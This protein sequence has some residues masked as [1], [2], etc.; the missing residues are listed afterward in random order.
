MHAITF[1][2]AAACSGVKSRVCRPCLWS[3]E[4]VDEFLVAFGRCV[5]EP[6]VAG[7][8]V[9]DPDA[10]LDKDVDDGFDATSF[11]TCASNSTA[12]GVEYIA[13]DLR[14]VRLIRTH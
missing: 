11:S 5:A 7:R 13:I 8:A 3:R 10:D 9:D 14:H 4:S 12:F 1:F 2:T 6:L